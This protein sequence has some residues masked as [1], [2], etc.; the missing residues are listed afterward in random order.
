MKRRI[1]TI[2]VCLLLGAMVN[3]AVAWALAVRPS[4]KQASPLFDVNTDIVRRISETGDDVIDTYVLART[5][6]FGLSQHEHLF[7][8]LDLTRM[9]EESEYRALLPRWSRCRRE[10]PCV[11][12]SSSMP[13]NSSYIEYASGW[14]FLALRYW[15]I[16]KWT[17]SADRF[18]ERE[19]LWVLPAWC[20]FGDAG[21]ST[22]RNL[23]F[24]PAWWGF[25]ANAALYA[26]VLWLLIP[27][28]FAL[29]RYVR[30]RR[31]R[32]VK[33]NYDLRGTAGERCPECG[34]ERGADGA[35]AEDGP[36]R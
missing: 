31:G 30:C 22:R 12:L 35:G 15:S 6:E 27:G 1:R 25:A 21:N 32:C 23:P 28:P 36:A 11:L 9:I 24:L 29:R 33:C 3:V 19:G 7:G 4:N 14:P 20:E 17:K 10:E 5:G 26:A 2:L 18:V 34:W 13:R 16:E 8:N